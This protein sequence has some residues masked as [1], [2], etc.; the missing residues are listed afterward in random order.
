MKKTNKI[1]KS[2]KSAKSIK[3]GSAKKQYDP[4]A[5]K[6]IEKFMDGYTE[7][8]T[9]LR[10]QVEGVSVNMF[11]SVV[12]PRYVFAYK[13]QNVNPITVLKRC[14]IM[15]YLDNGIVRVM[16]YVLPDVE[17][18]RLSAIEAES[19]RMRHWKS[20]LGNGFY[21]IDSVFI[22]QRKIFFDNIIKLSSSD[23]NADF[24]FITPESILNLYRSKRFEKLTRMTKSGEVFNRKK[25]EVESVWEKAKELAK[26]RESKINPKQILKLQNKKLPPIAD[27]DYLQVLPGKMSKTTKRIISQEKRIRKIDKKIDSPI[28]DIVGD[29]NMLEVQ[30]KNSTILDI[31][32]TLKVLGKKGSKDVTESLRRLCSEFNIAIV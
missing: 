23:T 9:M 19:K 11:P 1:G 26:E 14:N 3:F 29:K 28:L 17:K 4:S 13:R 21:V 16:E 15:W 24:F 22:K 2:S 6:E 8:N 32:T 12:V 27:Y 30:P 5:A 25:L 31:T 18:N 10:K 7:E 20:E